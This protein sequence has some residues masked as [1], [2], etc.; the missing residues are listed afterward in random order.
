MTPIGSEG[1]GERA[2][3]KGSGP[4]PKLPFR[5]CAKADLLRIVARA[6]SAALSQKKRLLRKDR[7]VGGI[8]H[9]ARPISAVARAAIGQQKRALPWPR[10]Q[11]S[12]AS[13]LPPASSRSIAHPF[14]PPSPAQR[15]AGGHWSRRG[16]RPHSRRRPRAPASLV[17]KRATGKA[18]Y[19]PAPLGG[20][21]RPGCGAPLHG[22]APMPA[23]GQAPP[24]TSG[25]ACGRAAATPAVGLGARALW[26]PVP[27][28]LVLARL[29]A[30]DNCR[31]VRA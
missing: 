16:H 23:G 30:C 27:L 9:A 13:G 10:V 25:F 26:P 7:P 8:R 28:H 17:T 5:A 20:P 2:P 12:S 4:T 18:A 11:R 6:T 14:G 24:P 15:P 22:G 1:G 19:L 29:R 3:K 31:P 21:R